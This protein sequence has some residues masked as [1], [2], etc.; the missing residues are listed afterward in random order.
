MDS[1]NE[2]LRPSDAGVPKLCR[3]P[4]GE[5]DPMPVLGP[6]LP[7]SLFPL[8]TALCSNGL[9]E[10]EKGM[11]GE[12]LARLADPGDEP[13]LRGLALRDPERRYFG[14]VTYVLSGVGFVV[15]RGSSP[16][17][18]RCVGVRGMSVRSS[19]GRKSGYNATRIFAAKYSPRKKKIVSTWV[20]DAR[21]TR[22]WST[23]TWS[24]H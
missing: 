23:L 19:F 1:F 24:T 22:T 16:K 10:G 8:A 13:I 17:R 2:E 6:L 11:R 9:G 5:G 15:A 4:T 18:A 20:G 7:L 14:G 21:R 12:T 3:P